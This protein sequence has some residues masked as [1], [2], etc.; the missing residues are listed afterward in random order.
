MRLPV[1]FAATIGL[2]FLASSVTVAQRRINEKELEVLRGTRICVE[3]L[4]DGKR[5]D[6]F[7]GVRAVF[8]GDN[9]TWIF[10]RDNGQDFRQECK[11][12]ISSSRNPKRFDWYTVDN[13]KTTKLRLVSASTRPIPLGK[14]FPFDTTGFPSRN[15]EQ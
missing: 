5:V 8:D 15:A 13:P 12:E 3:S 6:N 14:F 11:F 1:Y 10:P 9:M 7:V 4:L 2:M